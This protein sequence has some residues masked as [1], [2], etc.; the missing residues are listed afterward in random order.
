MRI[1]NCCYTVELGNLGGGNE[2]RAKTKRNKMYKNRI[3]NIRET[4]LNI[5]MRKGI[6]AT[7][8]CKIRKTFLR[9]GLIA[10]LFWQHGTPPWHSSRDQAQAQSPRKPC[11]GNTTRKQ[12]QIHAI[13]ILTCRLSNSRYK[14]KKKIKIK[15]NNNN[16][17]HSHAARQDMGWR[18]QGGETE[19]GWRRSWSWSWSWRW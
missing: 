9:K 12:T 3:S 16:S 6:S 4:N 8:L 2:V 18:L 7:F 5:R 14:F 11:T 13:Q 17:K 19:C 15:D 10:D 1:R